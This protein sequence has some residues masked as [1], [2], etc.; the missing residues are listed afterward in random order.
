MSLPETSA[1]SDLQFVTFCTGGQSFSIDITQVREIRRWSA[2]TPVPHSPA[3]VLGVMNLRGAVIPIFDLAVRFGLDRTPD[4]ARNVIVIAAHETK[5]VGLLVE[6]VS[7]ILSVDR[8]QIQDTP[9][10]RN[11]SA[12][13][14]V[15]GL[16]PF[17]NGMTRVIDLAEV[18]QAGSRGAR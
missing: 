11:E 14:A 18:I 2:V 3:E 5:T 9:D 8:D 12:K 10:L 17:E 13:Q 1:Q 15:T 16:I 4:N 6:S 7:E